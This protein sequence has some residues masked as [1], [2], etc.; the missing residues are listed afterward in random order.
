[1]NIVSHINI[2]DVIFFDIETAARWGSINEMKKQDERGYNLI[3]DRYMKDPSSGPSLND[4]YA[5]KAPLNA[6]FGRVVCITIYNSDLDQTLSFCQKSEDALLRQFAEK[7][8]FWNKLGKTYL[9]GCNIKKF[10][11]PFLVQRYI[12]QKQR[13]P[14]ALDVAGLKPWELKSLVDL[15]EIWQ[16]P[17]RGWSS[18]DNILYSCGIPSPKDEMDGSMVSKA[19]HNGD[20]QAIKT[21]CEK[22][23]LRNVSLFERFKET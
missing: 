10:D 13:I 2:E 8:K 3:R 1:M 7:L 19:F 21:Y 5:S 4:Y 16:G 11:V 15:R 20:L 12:S 14:Q 22:D 23:V 6:V 17:S 18:F 9:C